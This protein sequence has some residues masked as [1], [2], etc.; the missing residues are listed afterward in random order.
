MGLFSQQSEKQVSLTAL[1]TARFG[2]SGEEP[3]SG[4]TIGQVVCDLYGGH[5]SAYCLT[6]MPINARSD[7]LTAGVNEQVKAATS[8]LG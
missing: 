7:L 8:T 5:H 1:A 6:M 2:W 3:A 4:W